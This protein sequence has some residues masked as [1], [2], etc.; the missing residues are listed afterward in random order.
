[1]KASSDFAKDTLNVGEGFTPSRKTGDNTRSRTGINPAPTVFVLIA[2][3]IASCGGALK[4]DTGPRGSFRIEGNPKDANVEID[5]VHLGPTNMFEKQGVLLRPGEHRII[6]R[7]EGYFPEYRIV[8][9]KDGE[10]FVLKID[11]RPIPE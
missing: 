7:A 10:V 1:M 5:D 6:V 4:V 3:F 2:F 8:P 11:L 9:I